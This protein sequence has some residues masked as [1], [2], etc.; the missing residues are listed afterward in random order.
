MAH[1]SRKVIRLLS[2]RPIFRPH[3]SVA[4]ASSHKAV[5]FD[6]FGVLIPSPLP[7]ATEWEDK[8]G[9]P[10]GTIGQ[11]IRTGGD[12]NTWRKYMRGELGPEEFVEA[13]SRDCSRIVGF[14][15]HIGSFHSALSSA[16]MSRPVA[17][18]M[19]AVKCARTEGLKTAV[20]SNN[21]LLPEGKTYM[22]LDTFLF[23]V[24]VESCRVGLCKP[25]PRIYQLCAERLGVSPQEAVFLDDLSFNVEAAVQVGM[26]GIIVRDPVL[27]M[28][29]LEQVL[30]VSLSGFIPGTRPVSLSQQLPVDQLTHYLNRTIQLPL[31]EPITIRQF[32]HG[33]S[34]PTFL[35]HCGEQQFV[36]KKKPNTEALR[37]EF[38]LLK[39]LKEGGVP[40]PEVIALCEEASVM[41]TPFYLR[42][43][44][45]GRV[46]DDPFLHGLDT[47]ER[48]SVYEAM[49]HTLC[50]IH[51]TD[52]RS[53]G[54]ED[55][56]EPGDFMELEVKRLVKQYKA[57]ETQPIPAMDR[58][59][60]WLLSH[61]PTDRKTT[62]LHGDYRLE[63]LVFDA[64]KPEVRAVLGWGGF[65]LG[66]PLVDVASCCV[67]LYL[68]TPPSQPG[69]KL[70]LSGVPDAEDIFEL[71]SKVIGQGSVPN[72]QFY[73]AF[74]FFHQAVYL[75]TNRTASLKGTAYTKKVKDMAELGWDFA[76]KE[77]FRIFN[78]LPRAA[79]F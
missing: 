56:R 25:D 10:R 34:A 46:F 24:I 11:A 55:L 57:H 52:L 43:Y 17:V 26:H 48:K 70:V 75:Q 9:V 23:D 62:L 29:E 32:S 12:G 3:F 35:L 54:L 6:M 45:Q 73:M 60:E 65:T 40:V 31:T 59:L 51:C 67:S 63:N 79:G 41:D 53:T 77:G 30:N 47:D 37:K 7:K 61:L 5:I 74:R 13:F 22:P 64:E 39:A 27:A 4:W 28:K 33:D 2:V 19:E 14:E 49:I 21:F 1:L 44:C 18:M 71:Y 36:L 58:L 78:T 16:S 20:L 66:D 76:T 42:S 50:Q 38:R 69:N 15:V 8:N 68:S 72:W